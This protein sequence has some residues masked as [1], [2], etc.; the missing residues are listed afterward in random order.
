MLDVW[1]L[2]RDAAN[3]WYQDQLAQGRSE[4]DVNADLQSFDQWDRYD[5]DGDGNFNEPDGYIDHFQIVHAGGDEADGDPIYGDDA[6]WSHRWYAY[7]TDAGSTGP[8]SNQLG[9]TEIGTSGVW[10]GDYTMQPENGGRSVFYH[11]YGH[12]LGLPDDYNVLS[13][14]DNN[15]E[16]WTLMAQSRLDRQARR[17]HRRARR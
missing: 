17:R 12:D 6:I 4:A 3:I 11:E 2:V 15:N 1:A 8:A 16:Y 10:V 9:G 13:G 14:G 7:Y 5:F